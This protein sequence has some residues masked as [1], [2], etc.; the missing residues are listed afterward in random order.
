MAELSLANEMLREELSTRMIRAIYGV[1]LW[2]R[3]QVR[4]TDPS[5]YIQILDP[6][7]RQGKR[8]GGRQIGMKLLL[9]LPD[10][11]ANRPPPGLADFTSFW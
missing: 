4:I 6:L 1:S 9:P 8:L 2:H 5:Y 7:Y 11:R 3:L 10:M